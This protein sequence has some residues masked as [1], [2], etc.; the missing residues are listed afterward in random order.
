MKTQKKKALNHHNKKL[1]L[2]KISLIF[3]TIF[4]I[5]SI[6][7]HNINTLSN[8][9]IELLVYSCIGFGI[10]IATKNI[11]ITQFKED[12]KLLFEND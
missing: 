12:F 5:K 6:L 9:L 1:S 7:M 2:K 3:Y 10:Y 11:S 4:T 8:L